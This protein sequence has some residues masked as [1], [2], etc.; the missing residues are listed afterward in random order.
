M[1]TDGLW[2][3]LLSGQPPYLNPGESQV[4]GCPA[5]IVTEVMHKMLD[6]EADPLHYL[7][8]KYLAE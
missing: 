4:G 3:I 6:L 8:P 7:F 2:G 1:V 5:R